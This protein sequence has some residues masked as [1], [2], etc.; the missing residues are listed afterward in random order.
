M[1]RYC[2]FFASMNVGGNRLK[3]T[4]LRDALERE[5]LED[6]ET[7]VASGNVLFSFDDRPSDGLS[8]MLAFIVKDRFGF[9]TFAAVRNADEV[10]A[11]FEGNPFHGEGED[12]M[13]HTLFLDEPADPAKF[14]AM[15]EAYEGR[16]PERMAL[17]DGC[18]YVDYIES[19]GNSKLTGA[20]I[21]RRLE[22][23]VTG[24]NMSSLKRIHE[25]MV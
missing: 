10:R 7:V 9:A 22:R 11:A 13:V 1:P 16:G 20:F 14:E 15:V 5:D 23:R 19:V 18:I 4:D 2:A 6:A 8:E 24:R 25:K 12:K 3:M 21:E 17:G